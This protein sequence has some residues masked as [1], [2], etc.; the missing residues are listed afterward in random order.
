MSHDSQFSIGVGCLVHSSTR[1]ILLIQRLKQPNI[2]TLPSGYVEPNETLYQTMNRELREEANVTVRLEGIVGM[3]QQLAT[4]HGDNLWIL[5][6]GKY[7]GG[8]PKPDLV[9]VSNVAFFE[10]SD[11]LNLQLTPVTRH[12]LS[13]ERT[14]FL[15]ILTLDPSLSK[16]DY[17]FFCS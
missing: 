7:I 6:R 9:E 12:I 1:Q 16:E 11:A 2:W 10:I 14:G 15:G 13:Q 3:R 5:L 4:P 17:L 8:E